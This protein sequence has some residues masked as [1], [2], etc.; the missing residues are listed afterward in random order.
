M[1]NKNKNTKSVKRGRGRPRKEIKL[2]KSN[3]FTISDIFAANTG[4]VKCRLTIY[5][6]VAELVKAKTLKETAETLETGKVGK[7]GTIFYKM[8]A[9]NKLQHGRASRK[10]TKLAK[11][12]PVQLKPVA[13]VAPVAP[14]PAI[15]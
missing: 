12:A 2:P 1:E 10:V 6:R 7:P 4:N 9:W 8:A 15:A 11:A 3:K 13:P 14:V 5:T